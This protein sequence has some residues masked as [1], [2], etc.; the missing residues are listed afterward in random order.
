MRGNLVRFSGFADR[1]DRYRPRPPAVLT[2]ILTQLAAVDRP[3]L[4]VDLGSG[5]GLSAEIWAGRASGV[6]GIEPNADMRR[7]AEHRLA[8][9][10]D[11]RFQDGLS[12]ATGLPDGAA[13]IVTCSQSLH[14]MEPEPTFREIARILRPGGVFAAY[15]CDWPATITPEAEDRFRAFMAHVERVAADRGL[16]AGVTKWNKEEHLARMEASGWFRWGKELAVHHVETGDA[17]R[18]VG[19]ALSQGVVSTLLRAG[20]S[21]EEVG[22]DTYRQQA[23]AALPNGAVPWYWTYRVRVGIV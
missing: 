2:A 9:A 7:Q 8:G 4:V 19:I 20:M 16:E 1:Y 18:L 17:D 5:T 23:E 21:E 6:V 11:I 10:A 13:D 3:D 14:W 15:D 12:S 22:E